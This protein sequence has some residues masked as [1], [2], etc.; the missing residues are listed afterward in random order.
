MKARCS[1]LLG[2]LF[3]TRR[4]Q[5]PERERDPGNSSKHTLSAYGE[6][7]KN[8]TKRR[9]VEKILVIGIDS[10]IIPRKAS[11]KV[12]DPESVQLSNQTGVSS[13]K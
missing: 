5:T 8:K 6:S 2:V 9:Y 12:N 3:S 11:S 7:L 13:I 4:P 10:F 1:H